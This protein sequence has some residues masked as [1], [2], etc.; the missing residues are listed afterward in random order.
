MRVKFTYFNTN[1]KFTIFDIHNMDKM[2]GLLGGIAL[3]ILATGCLSD[4]EVSEKEVVD[5]EIDYTECIKNAIYY[6]LDSDETDYD[7]ISTSF[8]KE[9]ENY[10]DS[11]FIKMQESLWEKE[12]LFNQFWQENNDNDSSDLHLKLKIEIDSLKSTLKDVKKEVIG[13]MFVHTFSVGKD[14]SSMIFIIDTKCEEWKAIPVKTIQD[15]QPED[16]IK[17]ANSLAN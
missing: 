14:T 12:T 11:S 4:N 1:S 8:F 7:S 16:Y 2:R 5:Q 6:N 3:S 17:D 10:S 9:I 13:Y 15:Y